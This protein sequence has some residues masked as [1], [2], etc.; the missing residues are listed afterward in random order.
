MGVQI[1]EI[2]PK[3]EIDLDFLKNKILAVDTFNVLYQFLANIRQP[4]GTPLIDSKG[5][6]TSH[7]SGLFYRTTNLISKGI[8]LVYVFDGKPPELK[9]KTKEEREGRKREAKEKYEKAKEEGKEDEMLKY[10][11]QTAKLTEEMVEESKK[12]IKAL[13]LPCI[14]A[15][16]EGEAQCAFLVKNNDAFA[17]ASQDY[18]SLLFAA[19]R[20]I[21]NVTLAKKRHTASGIAIPIQPM[22]IELDS[23]LNN[24]QINIEQL[25][26][27]GILVGTDFNPQGIK[28]IGQKKALELV[29]KY[30]KPVLLFE[31]LKKKY[32]IDFD[33]R[34]IFEIFKKPKVT[35]NY[36]ID[37]K[38]IDENKVKKI[39]CDEHDFS[40]ER[41]SNALTKV[42]ESEEK[43]KQRELSEWF[44]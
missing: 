32:E 29:R 39:L 43:R 11:K 12:L 25:I 33:W 1:S 6:V 30:K 4:D 42:H 41:V 14:Q 21:Q 15:P 36:K 13:G 8:K 7:L 10:A 19:P 31:A 22:L 34:D 18:D 44:K 2:V 35:R 16:S 37:F 28:G 40:E 27:I 17:V 38:E 26:C 24:L 23:L 5:R 9:Y 3:K 20:L